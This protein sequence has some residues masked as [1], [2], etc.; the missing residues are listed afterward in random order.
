LAA[1]CCETRGGFFWLGFDFR[2]VTVIYICGLN[3]PSFKNLESFVVAAF[4]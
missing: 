1:P 3:F 2:V 4:Y